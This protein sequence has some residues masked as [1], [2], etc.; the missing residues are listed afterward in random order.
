MLRRAALVLVAMV[1]TFG[2]QMATVAQ[3]APAPAPVPAPEAADADALR[4]AY[5]SNESPSLDPHAI[6]DPLSFRIVATVYETL[7]MYAPGSEAR[8]VP[9]LAKDFPQTSEDGLTVTIKLDTSAKFHPSACFGDARTRALKASDVV[10]S[11][12]RLAVYGDNGMYWMAHG[13]IKGLDDYATKARYNMQYETSDTEVEGL[14]ASDDQTLVITLTRPYAPLV[15]L[16]AHPSFS[17]LPREAIDTYAGELRTRAVGTGP[18]RLNAVADEQLYVFKRWADFRG[19]KPAFERVTFTVRSFWNEFMQGY[20]SGELHEM[21][22]WPAYYDRVAKDG[23]PAGELADTETE[24]I[25]QDEHGY[26]FLSFN[27]DDP[28]WGAMDEDGR[29]LRRA[30]SLCMDRDDLLV[31]AGWDTRWASAQAGVFPTGMEF[32]DTGSELEFGAFDT[33]LAKK[34]LDGSKY[35][36][37]LDPATGKSLKLSFLTSDVSFYDQIVNGLR[38]GLKTLGIKLDAKYVDGSEYRDIVNKSEEQ[39][40][41]AGWFL[42]YPDPENFL[43][44]FWSENA[45]N[46]QEFNNTARYRSDEFDKLFLEYERLTPNDQNQPRRR[47]LTAAMAREIAKDQPIIPLV[48]R[49]EAYLRTSSVTWPSMP[50]QTYNDIRFVKEKK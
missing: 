35:K 33:K 22:L 50:R 47:E 24:I 41:T 9:C 16:L 32:Q 48:R 25:T 3:V 11:F 10:H 20:K 2:V 40:F 45:A 28:V 34:L 37:G 17:V 19:E 6:R 42:D 26:Y 14:K 8:I 36:G 31:N 44:L 27:M 4:I 23:K 38:D 29:A 43:Q 15:S 7:Y 1:C 12:K 18:Y 49:R 21:P 46:S 39:L 30:V 5:P 13:L